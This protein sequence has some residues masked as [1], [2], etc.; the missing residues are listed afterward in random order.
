[1]YISCMFIRGRTFHFSHIVTVMV[2]GA[3]L[4]ISATAALY[5]NL[6]LTLQNFLLSPLGY[7]KTTCNCDI[8]RIADTKLMRQIKYMTFAKQNWKPTTFALR[9]MILPSVRL[10][11]H[12]TT[13]VLTFSIKP[14]AF[15]PLH[16]TVGI[17]WGLSDFHEAKLLIA[18]SSE[19]S[20]KNITLEK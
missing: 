18:G 7:G 19:I 5:E 15:L 2:F 3:F 1:M 13:A 16:A 9:A 10:A 17:C 6:L 4:S 12:L 8:I 11:N 20:R 14:R